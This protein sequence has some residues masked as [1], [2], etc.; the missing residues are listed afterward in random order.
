MGFWIFFLKSIVF[1]KDSKTQSQYFFEVNKGESA[2][3]IAQ[4]LQKKGFISFWPAFLGYAVLERQAR[5]FQKGIYYLSPSW[6]VSQISKIIYEG[7]V[8]EHKI[9]I[10]EGYSTWQI[11]ELLEK[12]KIVS[13]AEFLK[14][15]KEK[16][17][18]LFPD[19]YRLSVETSA[20]LIL[21]EMQD[22]FE[23]K[24]KELNL[25]KEQMII[26]SI[27]EREVK[28][29]QDRAKVAGVYYNRLRKN[30]YLEADPTVQYARG[31]WE[32]ITTE[33]YRTVGL[34]YNT[35]KN[36]GLP[37]G[38]ICNPGLKSLTAAKN[39]ESS[40]FIYFFHLK[41]GTTVYSKTL[42]EHEQKKEENKDQISTGQ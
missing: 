13:F 4:N 38:P 9:T 24:T 12:K 33:D 6:K 2:T 20:K 36:K 35:Y 22:N 16:E 5:N 31:S 30:M 27:V 11:A 7:R 29:D 39:P 32:P 26:A 41:D 10:P 23:R 3:S 18:F 15:A 37:P 34:P 40:D 1:P 17:G 19:T 8:S 14:E 21:K 42:E 25:T 28:F